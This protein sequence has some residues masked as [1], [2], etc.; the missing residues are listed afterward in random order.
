MKSTKEVEGN[1]FV[2]T[3]W[4]ESEPRSRSPGATRRQ[5]VR[6]HRGPSA[7][8]GHNRGAALPA[9]GI[10]WATARGLPILRWGCLGVKV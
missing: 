2:S 8:D 10:R 7:A 5:V 6:L 3:E 1:E 4:R 9:D